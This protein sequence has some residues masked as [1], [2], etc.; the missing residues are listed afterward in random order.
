MNY[1]MIA[2]CAVAVANTIVCSMK[3]YRLKEDTCRHYRA[4]MDYCDRTE[5][6]LK[7][8]L[9]KLERGIAPDYEKAQE[10]ARA[11]N[12]FNSGITAILGY[13]PFSALES[14]RQKERTGVSE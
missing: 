7:T 8:R 12:N 5:K 3:I 11:L 2:M 10:A 1:L 4:V 6:E 9:D 13:D 14:E